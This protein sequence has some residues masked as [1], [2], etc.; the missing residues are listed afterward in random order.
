MSANPSPTP[1]D[2]GGAGRGQA[3]PEKRIAPR[4][5]AAAKTFAVVLVLAS[6]AGFV[7]FA[8]ALLVYDAGGGLGP[9]GSV[10]NPNLFLVIRASSL[11]VAPATFAVATWRFGV[12]GAVAS[13]LGVMIL[14]PLLWSV[15]PLSSV[16][17]SARYGYYDEGRGWVGLG[18]YVI[19]VCSFVIVA[20]TTYVVRWIWRRFRHPV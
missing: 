15:S 2:A 18:F 14:G 12:L 6:I 3:S 13:G 4:V 8:C 19:L 16:D 7:A 5:A 17:S 9:L 11:A 1:P 20:P 10:N